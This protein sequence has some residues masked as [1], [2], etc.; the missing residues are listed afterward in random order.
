MDKI[1]IKNLEVFGN[2][3]VFPEENTLGQKFIISAALYT[4]LHQAAVDDD[5]TKSIHYGLACQL[6][7]AFVEDHTFQL[8]ETLAE[9]L[10]F[11]MLMEIQGLQEVTLE[12][13]KPWAPVALPL[14]TVS[15]EI[16][17]KWHTAFI[18]LGSNIDDKREYLEE[19]VKALAE[20]EGCQLTAVSDFIQTVPYGFT[21]QDEFLNGCLELKTL[22][23]P[24]ELLSNIH[25]IE[26]KANRIRTVHW[27]P[28]TLD[29]DIIFYDDLVLDKQ[30]LQI[31]HVDMHRRDFVLLPLSQIAPFKRHPVLNKTVTELT[32]DLKR[33]K[34]RS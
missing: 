32:A 7:K 29:L 6:I 30:D 1:H 33:Q 16:T 3:G 13:K 4:D 8:V 19:G 18:A 9:R 12:I 34:G 5:L 20:T 24:E 23:T 22:L 25:E 15:I 17:R 21:E 14:E 10:A 31:P 27:G 26:T 11:K 2:H 28:R